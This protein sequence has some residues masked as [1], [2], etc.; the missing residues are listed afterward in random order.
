MMRYLA[1]KLTAGFAV[2]LVKASNL[3]P[4]PPA[5]IIAMTL[6][7]LSIYT[8]SINNHTLLIFFT[9]EININLFM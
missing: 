1:A 7:L 2:F 9:K 8:P 4:F 3:V 5:N 6:L